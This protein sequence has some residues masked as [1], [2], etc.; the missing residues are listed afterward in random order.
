MACLDRLP[1]EDEAA[2]NAISTIANLADNPQH[3]GRVIAAG[4][5]PALRTAL[6]TGDVSTEVAQDAAHALYYLSAGNKAQRAAMAAANCV[7]ALAALLTHE[8][9][10]VSQ[11]AAATLSTL[12]SDRDGHTMQQIARCCLPPLA[13]CLAR[14][15][16]A[17]PAVADAASV[18]AKI[19][20]EPWHRDCVTAAG[21]LPQLAALLSRGA[22]TAAVEHAARAL[23]CMA[24]GSKEHRT[25]MAAASCAP[26]LAALL[27]NE[28]ACAAHSLAV[29]TLTALASDRD[30]QTNESI[31]R[32]C[33][34]L[35]AP[36]LSSGPQYL[37]DSATTFI[38]HLAASGS[39][40]RDAVAI[41]GCMAPLEALLTHPSAA[42]A[43]KA[44]AIKALAAVSEAQSSAVISAAGPSRMV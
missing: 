35:L 44:S 6:C 30:A 2:Q 19:A 12:A 26:A 10:D 4:F 28:L 27:G 34:P 8:A 23:N 39:A 11:L 16:K 14:W 25:A 31:A 17:E 7:P 41:S 5:L 22:P 36:V 43:R 21:C 42:V 9:A 40:C 37:L 18:I 32:D 20:G 24:A 1:D 3:R 33:L 13:A 15:T 38:L 29:T